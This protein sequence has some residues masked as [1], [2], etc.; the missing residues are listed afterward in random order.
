[1]KAKEVP[2]AMFPLQAGIMLYAADLP[3]YTSSV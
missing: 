1:M 2:D 3:E